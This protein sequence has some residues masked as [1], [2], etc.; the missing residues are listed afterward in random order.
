M[1]ESYSFGHIRI[2]GSEYRSDVIIYPDRV[3]SSWWRRE[4]HRLY[5]EDIAEVLRLEPDVLVVGTGDTGR[6]KVTDEVREETERRGIE[7]IV[8]DTHRAVEAYNE[9]AGE[10]EVVAALHLTC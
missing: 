10:K 9:L 8:S 5:S 6:M 3:D 4:G 1:I 7:L 2:D